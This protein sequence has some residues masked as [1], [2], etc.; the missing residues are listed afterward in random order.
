MDGPWLEPR[1]GQEISLF[2]QKIKLDVGPQPH[3][4]SVGTKGYFPGVM[5]QESAAESSPQ[6]TAAIMN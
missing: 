6:S 1:Q 4:Y 3:S 5:S 2:S